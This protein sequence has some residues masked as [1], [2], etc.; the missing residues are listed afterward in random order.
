MEKFYN[1]EEQ[2]FWNKSGSF[3]LGGDEW[4]TRFG[5]TFEIISSNGCNVSVWFEDLIDLIGV[6][7]KI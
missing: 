1:I 3:S 2:R 7:R 6:F 5:S 4:S